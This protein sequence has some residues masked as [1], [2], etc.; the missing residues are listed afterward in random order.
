MFHHFVL[1]SNFYVESLQHQ[2]RSDTMSAF[3][4]LVWVVNMA[5]SCEERCTSAYLAD[6]RWRMVYQ[7]KAIAKSYL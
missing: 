7:V 3:L 6:L 5:V 1:R 4:W 2:M